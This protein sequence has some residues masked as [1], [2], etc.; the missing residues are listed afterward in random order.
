[1]PP[2]SVRAARPGADATNPRIPVG[3]LDGA[4]ELPRYFSLHGGCRVGTPAGVV[5]REGRRRIGRTGGLGRLVVRDGRNGRAGPDACARRPRRVRV[6]GV[7]LAAL[8]VDEAGDRTRKR[9]IRVSAHDDL[10]EP[11]PRASA[12]ER[13]NEEISSQ[14]PVRPRAQTF[15]TWK[16]NSPKKGTVARGR[17]STSSSASGRSFPHKFFFP[18]RPS[19]RPG[20][21]G[22]MSKTHK[23]LR[24]SIQQTSH[25]L[26]HPLPRESSA[27][28]SPGGALRRAGREPER[29]EPLGPESSSLQVKT[30]K[31]TPPRG[32]GPARPALPTATSIR[33]PRHTVPSTHFS[34]K[35][36]VAAHSSHGDSAGQRVRREE[37][38]AAL[39]QVLDPQVPMASPPITSSTRESAGRVEGRIRREET[40]ESTFRCRCR[41]EGAA[42]IG[43]RHFPSS[44][45]RACSS[46]SDAGAK[47]AREGRT[48]PY[49]RRKGLL[50][51]LRAD[52]S[53]NRSARRSTGAS[54]R[55]RRRPL[56]GRRGGPAWRRSGHRRSGAARPRRRREPPAAGPSRPP[57]RRSARVWMPEML[58]GFRNA[59]DDVEAL[60][61]AGVEE[62]E[63]VRVDEAPLL[64]AELGGPADRSSSARARAWGAW[65]RHRTRTGGGRRR[66]GG[67]EERGRSRP[68]MEDGRFGLT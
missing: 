59:D 34:T 48:S 9:S 41:V 30:K 53:Q 54:P 5:A 62:A 45:R 40:G 17:R 47:G 38:E 64:R 3:A 23:A 46:A 6:S 42:H 29:T 55:P 52:R 56:R 14:K 28:S 7:E 36:G 63:D 37:E 32:T 12:P 20:T 35:A 4:A 27:A 13:S 57:R 66:R 16:I 26:E 2:R 1:M 19:S 65:R 51:L 33:T 43:P 15:R 10:G 44:G 22:I 60:P 11:E 8:A 39:A 58:T 68:G 24:S 21:E 49:L 67:R 25:C 31:R 50:I 61:V 18:I